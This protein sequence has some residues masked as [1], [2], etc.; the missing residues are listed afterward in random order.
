MRTEKLK[1]SIFTT[2]NPIITKTDKV[3]IPAPKRKPLR[4]SF[5]ILFFVKPSPCQ[6]LFSTTLTQ[7]ITTRKMNKNDNNSTFILFQYGEGNMPE[8]IPIM[9]VP[10][11]SPDN[12]RAAPIIGADI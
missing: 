9:P 12:N 1:P 7:N 8:D 2:P 6:G 5:P 4:K 3:S 11:S 10:I